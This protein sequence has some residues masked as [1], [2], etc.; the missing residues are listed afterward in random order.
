MSYFKLTQQQADTL[1][2]FEYA[3]NQVFDPYINDGYGN[4]YV[5]QEMYDLLKDTE[6][7]KKLNFTKLPTVNKIDF[8]PIKL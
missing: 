8:K 3:P 2:R 6:Q 1:G 7:F 4:F 5:S